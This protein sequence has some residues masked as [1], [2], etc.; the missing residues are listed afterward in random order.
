MSKQLKVISMPGLLYEMYDFRHYNKPTDQ[1]I[2][3][4]DIDYEFTIS[5]G[6]TDTSEIES[7]LN[8]WVK[9]HVDKIN[10]I[11][12]EIKDKQNNHPF[13]LLK[14]HT[15]H[16]TRSVENNTII[17]K[18]HITIFILL[19]RE[20]E[21]IDEICKKMEAWKMTPKEIKKYKLTSQDIYSEELYTNR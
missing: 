21:I 13:V 6:L 16:Y 9:I 19:K 20:T 3:S 2:Q 15:I 12:K 17:S 14:E 8:Q 10:R 18:C 1:K 7:G 11:C 4:E 5:N